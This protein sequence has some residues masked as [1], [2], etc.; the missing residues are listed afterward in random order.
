M[1]HVYKAYNTFESVEELKEWYNLITEKNDQKND[2]KQS[3]KK[4]NNKSRVH[5]IINADKLPVVYSDFNK[6]PIN[7][8]KHIIIFTNNRDPKENKTLN[9]IYQAIDNLKKEHV[10]IIPE[11][12]VFIAAKMNAEEDES[13][14]W[15]SDGK[16]E[17]TIKDESN[18]DTLVFSR[19]GVQ[20][21][22]NCEHIVKVLQDR[23]FLVLNP[24]QASALACDKYQS[25]VLFKKGNIPQPRFCLMN[26]TV[27][28]DEKLYEEA[29]KDIYPDWDI[30]NTDKNED[31]KVVVKILDGHGGTGVFL[32]DGKKLYAILQCIFAIDP[33]RELIIQKK[34]EADGGDIRVHVLT[35]R[36]KQVI[37]AAMKRVKIG[38]DF[39]SNVSLGAEAEPVKLT[40]EQEQ[41]A[42]R[43]AALSHLPW[44]AVDIMPLVKGSNKEIG[45]NVVLEIN[46]SPGTQGI[47]DVI[48]HNFINVLLNELDDPSQF[49]L[50]DK[51]A[52][53][54]ESCTVVFNDKSS[55]TFL[56][57]LDT[58]NSTTAPT[59]EVGDF[60]IDEKNNKISF[61]INNETHNFDIIRYM[62]AIAGE[63]TYK[64]PVI[65]IKEI[66]LGLRRVDN[67]EIAIV[68]HRD[69]KTTNMLINRDILSKLGYTVHP[70]QSHILTPE[71]EKVKLI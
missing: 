6:K 25:A 59:L 27:L 5:R 66:Q 51:T 61:K 65:K 47:T 45:D 37:L 4:E 52:G 40:T 17:M 33:E 44:C 31:K 9:N 53:F 14:I 30:H 16:E 67:V 23:G 22:D 34:E 39:R 42:L 58:G 2:H 41:I 68:K 29:M 57:K 55:K 63:M 10:E 50:Q 70:S 11:L 26:K 35:L 28:Y 36:D 43:V 46:A 64:R 49:M 12:H 21:E 13:S 54:I 71:M 20:D 8:F 69:N 15:I 24:I 48:K 3:E 19:L 1:E 62:N 56:A 38:G 32:S 7:I 18:L 60:D